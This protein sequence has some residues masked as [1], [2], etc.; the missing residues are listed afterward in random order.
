VLV[1][2]G[3]ISQ[4][5]AQI[6]T[7]EGV[8]VVDASGRW[9]TPGIIDIHSHNGT[10]SLPLTSQNFNVSDV[11]EI[12]DPNV[13]EIW[14]E[15]GINPQ[16]LAF[17]RALAGGVTTLQVLPGSVPVFGGRSVVLKNVSAT[18]VYKMKFPGA[19]QGVKLACGENPKSHF[20]ESGDAPTSR[21]GEIALMRTAFLEAGRYLQEW[22]AYLENGSSGEPP[23]R[24]LELDTLAGILHGDF[25]VHVHC[26]T[27]DDIAVVLGVAREFGFHIDAIHH[28]AE[29]YKVP[30]LLVENNTCAAV[31]ADWWGYKL[32]AVDAIRENAAMLDAAGVCTILHSDSP[33]TG[34]RLNVEASKSMGA[35]RRAGIDIPP[36]RAIRWLTSNPARALGLQDQI[37]Q[38][39]AGFNADIVIWSGNPFSIYSHADQVYIDGAL[40]YDRL[41][42]MHQTRRDIELGFPGAGEMQ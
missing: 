15:H 36:E 39:S 21:M 16:D 19:Q 37:G 11:S 12:S 38:I 13:A 24:N 8:A 10:Y 23:E 22:E 7:V 3:K 30:E 34:Q 35:G 27:A 18:T 42:P 31:W 28:A 20:G 2:G 14:I 32:E 25:R 41:D 17:Q 26:Y 9:V 5:A 40:I 1:Q 6:P 29:A 33:V 4:V